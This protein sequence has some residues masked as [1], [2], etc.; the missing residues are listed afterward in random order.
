MEFAQYPFVYLGG[1]REAVWQEC[2]VQEHNEVPWGGG[3]VLALYMTWG[4]GVASY[5][6]PQKMHEPEKK[7][8]AS[9]FLIQNKINTEINKSIYSV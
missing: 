9:K 6:N 7:Y 3:G 8:L 4:F 1:G 5:G 2:H